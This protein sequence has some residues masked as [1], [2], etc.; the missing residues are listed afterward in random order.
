MHVLAF[1]EARDI[2]GNQKFPSRN[3][4][5]DHDFEIISNHSLEA[6]NF[7]QYIL[8]LAMML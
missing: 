4:S 8:N 1:P 6:F 5:S 2:L 7:F 3:K